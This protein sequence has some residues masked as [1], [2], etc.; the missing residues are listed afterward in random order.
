ME[1][2][3][4][5]PKDYMKMFRLA[6]RCFLHQRVYDPKEE[7]LVYL[8]DIGD[9]WDEEVEAYVGRLVS[10]MRHQNLMNRHL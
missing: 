5:V 10:S 4:P 3:K 7:K 9:D 2:K 8:T 1:C 6:E